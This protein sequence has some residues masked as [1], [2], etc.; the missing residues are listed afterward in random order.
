[1]RSFGL[2][3][4]LAS[5]W[6]ASYPLLKVSV[7]T[8]PP[9]TVVG[10]RT[11]IGGLL[12][13]AILGPRIQLF[14]EFRTGPERRALLTQSFFNCIL[15]FVLVAFA[16]REIDAGLATI[17]NSLSPIF[18]FLLTA[19]V[20]HHEPATPRKFVGVVLGLAGVFV[21]IGVDA[22]GGLGRKTWAELACVAGA[23]S[24]AMAGVLGVRFA[25]VTP[26]VPA[27]GITLIAA[28]TLLPV[29]MIVEQPWTAQPSTRSMAA[30]FASGIFSTGLAMVV[31]FRLLAT[32]GSIAMSSQAYLRILVGVGLSAAFLGERPSMNALV[33][34]CFVVLG[35]VAM[36]IP[37]RR[38]TAS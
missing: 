36:T 22:L 13:L 11:L 18:I 19:L 25:R 33:G 4:L 26:L 23:F 16:M 31:Y 32:I 2:V 20:T 6:G 8:I 10:L 29:A 1:M 27:A 3:L 15:P 30:L 28:A 38:P 12:L 37:A 5:L 7:E 35:V 14:R 21:I 24:F 17:L 9:I 34:L